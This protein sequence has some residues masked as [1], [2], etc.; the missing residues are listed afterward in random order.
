MRQGDFNEIQSDEFQ[1]A[2]KLS[3]QYNA[4]FPGIILSVSYPIWMLSLRHNTL[5]NTDLWCLNI[6]TAP[7]LHYDNTQ[8]IIIIKKDKTKHTSH[9]VKCDKIRAGVHVFLNL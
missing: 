2:K 9:E 3:S 4:A 1:I 5:L 6:T 8:M 7:K